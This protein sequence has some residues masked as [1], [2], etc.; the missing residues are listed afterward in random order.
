MTINSVLIA[1]RGTI[2]VRIARTLRRL[3]RQSIA[4]Y[5]EDDVDS[6]HI[7][8]CDV[9]VCLGPGPASGT[10]LNQE[11]L[12][13]IANETGAKAIHPGYG[14]LSENADFERRCAKAS[15]AFL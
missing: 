7:D 14:F 12:L 1:N 8:S 5:A 13:Q 4:V 3:Q 10:Y 6:A 2:A 9:A 15:I 11:R